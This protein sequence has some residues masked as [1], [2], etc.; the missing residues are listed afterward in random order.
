MNRHFSNC[1][2][3]S[4]GEDCVFLTVDAELHLPAGVAHSTAGS[5]GVDASILEGGVGE[6]EVASLVW[7]GEGPVLGQGLSTLRGGAG[8]GGR[9]ENSVS[10][11]VVQQY[12]NT[13][14]GKFRDSLLMTPVITEPLLWKLSL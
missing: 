8:G 3:F 7:L 12:R 14:Q 10:T 11:G 9:G 5:A 6:V 13:L 2:E 1:E 4:P